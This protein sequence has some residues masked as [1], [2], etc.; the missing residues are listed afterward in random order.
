LGLGFPLLEQAHS[1]S[2]HRRYL[3]IPVCRVPHFD[4]WASAW[5][6]RRWRRGT[7][8]M[9]LSR[10]RHALLAVGLQ[11]TSVEKLAPGIAGMGGYGKA[12]A[13]P[14]PEAW[15]ASSRDWK[16]RT[17]SQR[18]VDGWAETRKQRRAARVAA[19]QLSPLEAAVGGKPP[20]SLRCQSS[21]CL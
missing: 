9:G 14:V 20:T 19:G 12:A 16:P 13:S 5:L 4:W 2:A 6:L 10:P 3:V 18:D 11:S 17:G 1:S 21:C 15:R 7:R 8:D